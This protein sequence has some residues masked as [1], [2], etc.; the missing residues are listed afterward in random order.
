MRFE[1]WTSIKIALVA[2]ISASMGVIVTSLFLSTPAASESRV[3]FVDRLATNALILVD[4]NHKLR[5]EFRIGKDGDPVLFLRNSN[6]KPVVGLTIDKFGSGLTV[7]DEFGNPRAQI[8]C[9]LSKSGYVRL[10]D[11]SN[12]RGIEATIFAG[13]PSL[14]LKNEGGNRQIEL[15]I[16]NYKPSL[17]MANKEGVKKLAIEP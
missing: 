3:Q 11:S 5:G 7:T 13:T 10:T 9:D 15:A 6:G 1:R 16:N 14:S 2:F 8:G 4:A 12:Q 17:S